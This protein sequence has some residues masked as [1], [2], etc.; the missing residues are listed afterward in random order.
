M[1]VTF[2]KPDFGKQGNACMTF[3]SGM[4][5]PEKDGKA[6]TDL[7]TTPDASFDASPIRHS[8]PDHPARTRRRRANTPWNSDA[9]ACFI[10]CESCCC[11]VT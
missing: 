5:N 7:S 10:L 2:A 4:V 8:H 3:F 6:K 11:H 1:P 9:A